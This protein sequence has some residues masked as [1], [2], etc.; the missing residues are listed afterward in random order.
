MP[1]GRKPVENP[2]AA[3]HKQGGAKVVVLMFAEEL[4]VLDALRGATPRGV[5]LR[6]MLLDRAGVDGQGQPTS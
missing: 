2:R 6:D 5:Y 3:A 1:R 4:A